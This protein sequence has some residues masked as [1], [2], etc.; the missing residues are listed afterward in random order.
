M[1][2]YGL[3]KGDY[4]LLFCGCQRIL[5][6]TSPCW[7]IKDNFYLNL[8]IGAQCITFNCVGLQRSLYASL[9]ANITEVSKLL[10]LYFLLNHRMF[11]S[12]SDGLVLKEE[13][14]LHDLP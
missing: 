8:L 1:T 10:S 11:T 6:N 9:L 7:V 5:D 4:T 12:K 3:D 13:R 2:S 14:D